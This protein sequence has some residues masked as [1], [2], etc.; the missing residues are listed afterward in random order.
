[1]PD[2]TRLDPTGDEPTELVAGTESAVSGP[3]ESATSEPP[4]ASVASDVGRDEADAPTGGAAPDLNTDRQ[5]VTETQVDVPIAAAAGDATSSGGGPDPVDVADEARRRG[6]GRRMSMNR[7]WIGAIV[8]AAV[9][10]AGAGIALGLSSGGGK[11]K[12]GPAPHAH[13]SSAPLAPAGPPCPL[14]GVPTA[15][16]VPQRPALAIKIDNFPQA[17][18]QSGLDKADVVFEEPVEGGITRLVAVFQCQS[19]DL[20]GPIRSARAVDLQI[21]D[22]LSHP[23]F[24]H[25]GGIN[26]VI[27]MLRG[28]DLTDENLFYIGSVTQHPPGRYA[29][30]DTYVS[31]S[32]AWGL[33]ASD[34]TP[35]AAIFTYSNVTPQGTAVTGVH[36]P[37]A[38]TNDVHWAWDA[39]SGRWLLSWGSS[40]AMVANGG[41]VAATNIVIQ[42]VHVT[43]GPWLENDVGGLEVQSQMVGSGP[44]TVLRNGIAVT[45]TWQRASISSPTNLVS[46][47]GTPIALAPGPT[48]VEIVPSTVV[49]T[50]TAPPVAAS[51]TPTH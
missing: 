12:P 21:L 31:G 18:P 39:P 19:P 16:Q 1:M 46:A 6:H 17:R 26:P 36:I 28:G 24:L 3:S 27:S 41:Q 8:A 10:L 42:T 51:A 35:P 49:V 30:Y 29:P 32:G 14:T 44:A 38:P 40:P 25:V 4:A 33:D 13:A 48:W 5:P 23:V 34:T 20:A 37:F 45:G 22:E 11:K 50:T 9:V 15:T 47:A 7:A 43:Y 2:D